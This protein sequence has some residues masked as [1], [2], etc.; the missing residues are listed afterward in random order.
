MYNDVIA[1]QQISVK[2][3]YQPN[4]AIIALND[5]NTINVNPETIYSLKT[6][7]VKE[8]S[9]I[10]FY[11]RCFLSFFLIYFSITSFNNCSR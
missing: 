10:N 1:S 8:Y 5:N 3:I 6:S 9:Q 4:F 11:S 7:E 2:K